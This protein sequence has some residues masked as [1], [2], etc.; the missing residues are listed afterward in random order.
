M[1]ERKIKK[2]NKTGRIQYSFFFKQQKRQM[3]KK[4]LKNMNEKKTEKM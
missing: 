3:K 4:K 1:S 2:N